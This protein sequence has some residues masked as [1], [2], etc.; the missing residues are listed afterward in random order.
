MIS[1]GG[2][3]NNS[4]DLKDLLPPSMVLRTSQVTPMVKNLPMKAMQETWVQSLSGEDLL[5]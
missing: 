2:Q 4:R 1:K 5:E 3:K